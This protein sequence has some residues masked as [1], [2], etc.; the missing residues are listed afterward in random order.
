VKSKFTSR[1]PWRE[2]MERPQ[3]PKLVQIP[4]KMARFGKGMMLIPA[5]KLVDAIVRQVPR[6]RL[7][8]V[9]E[10]RRKLAADFSADVACPLTTGIFIRIVAEASEEDRAN[11]RKRV[12]PYW[13]VIKD[14]GSLNP[15]FPGGVE[16]QARYLRDEGWATARRGNRTV[17]K[18][19]ERRLA[20][21]K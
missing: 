18:D 3:E 5:P 20:V 11:G 2:K 17:L 1:A 10:I 21:L 7:V 12:A 8:T 15:K 14:D 9:A 6:G 4:P 16:Q 19:F 13:R